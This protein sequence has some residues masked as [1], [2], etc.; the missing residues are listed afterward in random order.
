MVGKF[1][2]AA[3]FAVIYV[4]A[5][6]LMPTVV[7]SQVR[8]HWQQISNKGTIGKKNIQKEGDTR[9]VKGEIHR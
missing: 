9:F 7:R 6:E 8:L 4:Y 5:G 2:I 3:S 1:Q